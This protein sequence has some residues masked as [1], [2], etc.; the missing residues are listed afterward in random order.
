M[1]PMKVMLDDGEIEALVAR[2]REIAGEQP[3]HNP[4]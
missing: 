3:T 1:V 2:L 4:D